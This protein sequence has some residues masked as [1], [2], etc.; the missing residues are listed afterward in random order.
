MWREELKRGRSY[1]ERGANAAGPTWRMGYMGGAYMREGLQGAALH[2][3]RCYWGAGPTWMEVTTPLA[4]PDSL[5][6]TERTPRR[7]WDMSGALGNAL[8]NRYEPVAME[9]RTPLILIDFILDFIS[10]FL[11]IS[12]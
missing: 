2:E 7:S 6:A 1:L 10:S 4:M 3:G 5:P 9:T 11:S 12:Y 8:V